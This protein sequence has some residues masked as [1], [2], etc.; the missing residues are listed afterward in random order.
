MPFLSKRFEFFVAVRYLMAKRKQA[1]ISIITGISVIGVA[2]GVMALVI[3]LAVNAGFRNTLQRNLLGA[4]AHINVLENGSSNGIADWRELCARAREVPHVVAAAPTLWDTVMFTGGKRPGG[5]FLKGVL[6]PGEGPVPEPLKKL[7]EGSYAGWARVDGRPPII[8][9]SKLAEQTGMT[10]GAV[11][12]VLSPQG[13]PTP[14]GN[15][16]I[17]HKFRVIGI[18]ESGFF[19]VDSTFAFASL[20]DVQ[21]VMSVSDVVN[22]VE[23]WIDDIY[24]APSVAREVEKAAGPGRAANTWM[25]QHKQLLGALQMERIV[26]VITIGLIQMVAALNILISLIMM[27]MEKHRDIAILMSMGARKEQVARIFQLQGLLIGVTGT[28]IGLVAGYALS[29]LANRGQWVRLPESVYSLSFVPFEPRMLD[30]V[31]ISAAALVVSFLATIYPARS[32]ARIAPAESLR[33]E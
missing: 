18:F 8:L 24:L 22:A 27:V 7:K 30:G 19:E 21:R 12:A 31:W 23:L 11:V 25:E 5:G 3:A 33:Y 26:T 13:E 14:H 2:A 15:R 16:L 17:E 10:V 28:A 9:G 29:Y 32:A 4:S 1:A 20:K 6:G